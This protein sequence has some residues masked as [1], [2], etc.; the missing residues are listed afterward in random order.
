MSALL[1][2][3]GGSVFRMIWGEVAD[4]VKKRQEHAQEM[5]RARFE[6]DQDEKR[7][8]RELARI[9]LQSQLKVEEVRVVGDVAVQKAEADA[10]VE[11][12]RNASK[13]TGIKWVDAWNGSIRPAAASIAIFLWV[14]ALNAQGYAMTEWDREIVGV[15]LG[16]FFA[17][18]SL[19]KRKK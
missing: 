18:R 14:L 17:D 16:F 15:V 3:L 10:F 6:A 12:M 2:F 8:E 11:A 13:P 5:E 7:H 4:F 1:S 19:A 9:S